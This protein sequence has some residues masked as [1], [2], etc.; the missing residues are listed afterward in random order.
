MIE[1][2][3]SMRIPFMSIVSSPAEQRVVLDNISWS[4]YLAILND[5][6]NR[7]GRIAYDQGVLEIMAPSKVHEKVK[8]LIGRMVEVFTEE[9]GIEVESAGS[10]TF[11]REDLARGLEPDECYY[12]QH[13]A[14]VRAKDEI[15]LTVDPPPDLVIEVDISRS[16]V[17]KFPI[18]QALGIPEVWRYEGD[19]LRIHVM[20]SDRYVETQR[21][22][23]LP[24][25]PIDA[26]ARCLN[27]R[28]RVDES[29]LV[30]E[31]RAQV[32]GDA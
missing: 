27:Q 6:G 22:A 1:L 24:Q 21:S 7:R 16:S 9:R 28:A 17:N 11:K 10:T 26:V 2:V 20:P 5:A 8:R 15:D 29:Q 14:A 18:Y 23:V 4:T 13:A 30:R 3:T 25:L 12:L 31:F 19:C 32:M